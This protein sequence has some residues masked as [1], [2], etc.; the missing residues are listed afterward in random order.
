MCDDNNDKHYDKF[1][2]HVCINN[3]KEKLDTQAYF[4]TMLCN[5]LE[6]NGLKTESS[7]LKEIIKSRQIQ[8]KKEKN[9]IKILLKPKILSQK[10][11]IRV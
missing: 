5:L 9:C 11:N 8:L 2:E 10:K 4:F 6:F 7:L 3:L 1:A